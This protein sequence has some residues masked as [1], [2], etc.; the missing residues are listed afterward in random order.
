MANF[1]PRFTCFCPRYV[2]IRSLSLAAALSQ[3]GPTGWNKL[4]YKIEKL[5]LSHCEPAEKAQKR[6]QVKRRKLLYTH[7]DTLKGDDPFYP[8][9]SI[10]TELP[11][12]RK[13]WEPVDARNYAIEDKWDSQQ[14]QDLE[15]G[16]LSAQ[17]WIRLSL[18]RILSRSLAQ[19]GKPLSPQLYSSL[20]PED[21]LLPPPSFSGIGDSSSSTGLYLDDPAT[22]SATKLGDLLDRFSNQAWSLYDYEQPRPLAS[23]LRDN[24]DHINIFE[25]EGPLF[26]KFNKFWH[27]VLSQVLEKSGV[28]DGPQGDVKQRLEELGSCF[29]CRA[30]EIDREETELM[31]AFELVSSSSPFFL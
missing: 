8:P 2:A 20:H 28:E 17:R 23:T 7:Y 25:Y 18:A 9:F 13:L 1:D 15:T 12:I 29:S 4:Y 31:P 22:T 6:Q 5:F 14:L 3:V 11:S 24:L 21:C 10:F 30:C 27:Q 16:L 26:P 19:L